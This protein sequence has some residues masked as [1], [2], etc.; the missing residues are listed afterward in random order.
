MLRD[1]RFLCVASGV[2]VVC[3]SV[4]CCVLLV[5]LL[6]RVCGLLC[7]ARCSSSFAVVDR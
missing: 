4:G 5:W 6:F 1:V 7:G 3:S 2:R